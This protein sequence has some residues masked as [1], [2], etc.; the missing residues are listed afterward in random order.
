MGLE[1]MPPCGRQAALPLE[2][3]GRTTAVLELF[4]PL[5]T[6]ETSIRN[7]GR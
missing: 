5:E 6:R 2:Q 4:L 3:G 1:L 7:M